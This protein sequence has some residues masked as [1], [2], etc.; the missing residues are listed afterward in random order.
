MTYALKVTG[1]VTR[2][3]RI[4]HTVYGNPIMRV[5]IESPNG[6]IGTYRISD[7]AGIVYG[8]KNPEYRDIVH[9]FELTN[10]GRISG[11]HRPAILWE[12]EAN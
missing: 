5:A 4:G 12:L 2:V 10:A 8:I 6:D 3:E 7:N 9:T 1:K 11:R